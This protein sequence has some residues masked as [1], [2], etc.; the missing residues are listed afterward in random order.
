MKINLS[1]K[2]L[3]PALAAAALLSAANGLFAATYNS[4]VQCR[5]T[6]SNM[7]GKSWDECCADPT[8]GP[9]NT[10]NCCTYSAQFKNANPS[11]CNAPKYSILANIYLDYSNHYTNDC[12]TS[13]TYYIRQQLGI[14]PSYDPI[15]LCTNTSPD[16]SGTSENEC[17]LEWGT[18]TD[19]MITPGEHICVAVTGGPAIYQCHWL[20]CKLVTN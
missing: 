20:G 19:T 3:Y 12:S 4:Y 9:L 10:V 16:L 18:S 13:Y 11:K 17:R 7:G 5:C 2:L 6:Q 14:T 1:V 8:W 15:P